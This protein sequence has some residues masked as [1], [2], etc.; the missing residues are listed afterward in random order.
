MK[1]SRSGNKLEKKYSPD[2]DRDEAG[3]FGS[4]GGGSSGGE[5]A[6]DKIPGIAPAV[7]TTNHPGN[8]VRARATNLAQVKK[9]HAAGQVVSI[10]NDASGKHSVFLKDGTV[11]RMNLSGAVATFRRDNNISSDYPKDE[12][13]YLH[14]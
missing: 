14:K 13:R 11:G 10:T 7:M 3:R 12:A 9:L 6:V 5:S 4:G 1:Y 2:Q 8:N